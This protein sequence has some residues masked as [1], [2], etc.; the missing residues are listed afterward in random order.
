MKPRTTFT[1]FIQPPDFG[2]DLRR[3]GNMAKSVKGMASAM[4]KPSMPIVGERILPW[5]DTATRRNPMIGPVQE[6]D[7]RVTK[8][9]KTQAVF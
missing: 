2:A 7:T 5:V 8:S 4:A 3:L 6:N 9:Q 1:T